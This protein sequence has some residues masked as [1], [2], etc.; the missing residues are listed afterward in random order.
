MAE[1]DLLLLF[2]APVGDGE[3]PLD[4]VFGDEDPSEQVVELRAAGR[5]T[6]LRGVAVVRTL[7]P[8]TA[9]GRITGLRGTVPFGI[10]INVARPVTGRAPS[11]FQEAVTA[12]APARSVYQQ[13][14]RAGSAVQERWRHA[15]QARAATLQHWQDSLRMRAALFSRL[16]DGQRLGRGTAQ[17]WQESIRRRA[18]AATLMQDAQRRGRGAAQAW[19]ESIRLRGRAGL[20]FGAAFARGAA[21][22]SSLTDGLAMRH[23]WRARYE[24]AMRPGPG[25]T[26]PVVPPTEPPCYVPGLP[27]HLVFYDPWSA[28]ADLLFV[29]C[30]DGPGPDPGETVVVPVKE[31]YLTI[32]SALLIRLD[33]GRIIPATTLNMSLDA[34]SWTW[35]FSAAVPGQA[36]ADVQPNSDGDPVVVQ[37]TVNGT[38]FNF[39]LERIARDRTFGSSQ[40][41][42]SGRG[43]GAELDA[44]YAPEMSFGNEA[45]RTARQLVEDILT[46]NGVP[47]GWTV[48]AWNLTDWL[49]PAGVFNHS[50]SYISAV[51]AVVGAAGA[52]V[53]PHN[54]DRSL[55]MHLRYPAPAWEWDSVTPNFELPAAVT[56]Q[57]SFEW[58]EKPR[59]NRAFVIGQE[60]GVHGRYTRSG[61]AG[62]LPAPTVVDPLITHADAVRQRGRAVLSDTGR[63]A[64]VALR[65]PVLAETGIIK[66]GSF[67]RYVEGGNTHIGLSRG[68]SVDVSM[69]TIYQTL[70]LETHVEPV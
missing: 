63:I 40:L 8:A 32:N 2:K 30:K 45:P 25:R 34:D 28:S 48:A 11:A 65:M 44:P 17:A 52:Y 20:A 19:Q 5:I 18:A 50:G 23:P 4:L 53:Q 15:V 62:D 64:T 46:L 6:R 69:P 3:S 35:Q 26:P 29:C 68:V 58:T 56:T 66:P 41:R 60:H 16:H 70:T 21:V 7:V 61:T 10:D 24:E 12:R 22:A 42:V 67:V 57:E 51:N 39:A 27:A 54:T 36:L 37:A 31:V 55:L 38:P 33:N 1:T 49:V 59:Y 13:A 9:Q 47:I 43:L 14:G